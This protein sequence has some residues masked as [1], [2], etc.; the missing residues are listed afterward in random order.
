VTAKL[1]LIELPIFLV[2][3]FFLINQFGVIGANAIKLSQSVW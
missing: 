2:M 1:H 3:L